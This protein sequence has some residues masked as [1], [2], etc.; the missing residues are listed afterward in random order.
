MERCERGMKLEVI[1]EASEDVKLAIQTS[2]KYIKVSFKQRANEKQG[3]GKVGRRLQPQEHSHCKTCQEKNWSKTKADAEMKQIIAMLRY[4]CFDVCFMLYYCFKCFMG[5]H[6]LLAT[7]SASAWD[8]YNLSLTPST[9][10]S[11]SYF[12]SQ[13]SYSSCSYFLVNFKCLWQDFLYSLKSLLSE[14]F[15]DTIDSCVYIQKVIDRKE[16]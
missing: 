2:W 3:R 9:T 12:S 14:S 16:K 7:S 15:N 10:S 1:A 13:K 4:S 8:C 5:I 11:I 6:S